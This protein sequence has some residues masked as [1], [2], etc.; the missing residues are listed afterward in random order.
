MG[1]PVRD[2]PSLPQEVDE[3]DG[4]SDGPF[5][6]EEDQGEEGDADG[7]EES[8]SGEGLG[9]PAL[10]PI[11]FGGDD[12]SFEDLLRMGA[13]SGMSLQ[14]AK[15][16]AEGSTSPV[17]QTNGTQPH[18][19]EKRSS[20]EKRTSGSKRTINPLPLNLLPARK[21]SLRLPRKTS[22]TAD[23]KTPTHNLLSPRKTDPEALV[24][25]ETFDHDMTRDT[26]DSSNAASSP[27]LTP[28]LDI[29]AYYGG[30]EEEPER[31]LKSSGSTGSRPRS[32]KAAGGKRRASYT[33]LTPTMGSMMP[34]TTPTRSASNPGP[35]PSTSNEASS[36]RTARATPSTPKSHPDTTEIVARRLKEAINDAQESGATSVKI[37]REFLE[38]VYMAVLS[39]KERLGE[40]K[41]KVDG[42]RVSVFSSYGWLCCRR[43]RFLGTDVPFPS[44]SIRPFRA[45]PPHLHTPLP[46][47]ANPN[48]TS[49]TSPS[50]KSN[51]T[52]S[53]VSVAKQK[54]KSRGS[55]S[56]YPVKPRG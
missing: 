15:D 24:L 56:N 32:Q 10:P 55:K 44:F 33:A 42:M 38:M 49:T 16:K 45:F 20:K 31:E 9:M 4:R 46:I 14:K 52:Q 39:G 50:L 17:E 37:D 27:V 26:D 18:A 29:T 40:M 35:A 8:Q 28:P 5:T 53:C 7:E 34:P 13:E 30:G 19:S 48:T 25:S 12:T 23:L 47:S 41:G 51:S 36:G 3:D 43:Y 6:E 2:L 11:E 22:A 21:E 54:Q 1:T